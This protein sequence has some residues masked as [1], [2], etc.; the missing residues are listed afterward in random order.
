MPQI[1]GLPKYVRHAVYC[2][3]SCFNGISQLVL[4][5]TLLGVNDAL[6][7]APQVE[8]DRSEI[9]HCEGHTSG[10]FRPIHRPGYCMTLQEQ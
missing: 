5:V 4:C 7:M 10:L 3:P 9:S 6:Q 2:Y 1:P 8:V